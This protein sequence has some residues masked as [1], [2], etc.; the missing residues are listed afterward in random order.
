MR[1]G[2]TG[3]EAHGLAQDHRRLAALAEFE[4]F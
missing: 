3:P 1:L 2:G 4:E